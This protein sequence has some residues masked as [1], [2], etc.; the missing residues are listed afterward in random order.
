MKLLFLLVML[1]SAPV[2]A[3][4][5]LTFLNGTVEMSVPAGFQESLPPPETGE[6]K[7]LHAA[8]KVAVRCA[9]SPRAQSERDFLGISEE[10]ITTFRSDP[11]YTV[12]EAGPVTR[13]GRLWY[14][15]IATYKGGRMQAY[16]TRTP[17]DQVFML[18]VSGK[19]GNPRIQE[20]V[21]QILDSVSI[22]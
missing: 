3:Q 1:L 13:K 6:R 15:Y 17:A 4:E 22:R 18:Q 10:L 19:E 12:H 5:T 2:W 9:G 7:F 8:D 16:T 20:T 14:H 11:D 21:E